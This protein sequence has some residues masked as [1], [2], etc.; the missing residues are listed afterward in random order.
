[1][2]RTGRQRRGNIN[3]HRGPPFTKTLG[4]M[5]ARRKLR[6]ALI[7]VLL[8]PLGYCTGVA[9][10]NYSGYCFDRYGKSR[11]L[12]DDERISRGIGGVLGHYRSIRFVPEEMFSVGKPAPSQQKNFRA[13]D[14][15]GIGIT[16][17]QLIL[18][19]DAEEFIAMNPDC[20]N[21]G[22]RGLYGEVGE[23]DVFRKITGDSAGFFNAKY[24]IR[25]RDSNGQIQSRWTGT[26]FQETNCGHGVQYW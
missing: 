11:F 3:G 21:F 22:R 10:L 14:A 4:V 15:K 23:S 18:Y 19:R 17:D 16:Q 7:V 9:G 12:S 5:S 8:I 6:G 1:M 26:T 24:Q 13:S 2:E 20:C 25:Y